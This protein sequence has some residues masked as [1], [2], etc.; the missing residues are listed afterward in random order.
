MFK[1]SFVRR[2]V[3]EKAIEERGVSF[4]RSQLI[5]FQSRKKFGLLYS[6]ATVAGLFCIPGVLNAMGSETSAIALVQGI[7][8]LPL[9]SLLVAVGMYI[10]NDLVDADLDRAN[11]KKRPLPSGLVSKRQAKSF[12]LMTNGTAVVLSI[13]TFNPAS[14]M[15]VGAM[16][17]IGILYSAPRIALMKRFVIKNAAIAMFYML[18]ALLGITSSY[19]I[20]LA[21]SSPVV[22][23]HVM[24]VFGI[25]IFVG[26]IVNDL[27]DIKGD[28]AEGRR[29]VPI[30]IGA[31]KTTKILMMMLASMPMISWILYVLP[32]GT[33]IFTASAVS[34]LSLLA[35]MRVR[36]MRKGSETIDAEF[37][38]QQHKKWF[39][40]HM[41]LQ[42]SL[43]LAALL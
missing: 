41:V 13:I 31:E 38:R 18:C 27:G 16:L 14:M 24:A 40:L 2:E 20:G 33:S 30:V 28:R 35:L 17:V 39:P 8:P 23:V 26:S 15:I 34:I 36:A 21:T 7:A 37:M 32:P 29:T 42:S 6:L 11:G 4:I 25:M 19:G 22:P 5:L 3:Q 43:V 10:L 12:I 9:V 1:T